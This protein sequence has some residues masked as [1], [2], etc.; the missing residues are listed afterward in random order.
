MID[1]NHLILT[2]KPWIKNL[3]CYCI[4]SKVNHYENMEIIDFTSLVLIGNNCS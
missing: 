3:N 2:M 4:K 1:T